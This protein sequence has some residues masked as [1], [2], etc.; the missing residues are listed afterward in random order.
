[1]AYGSLGFWALQ[2][3]VQ[4]LRREV[5]N[6]K[7]R[8]LHLTSEIVSGFVR[9]PVT[10]LGC[11]AVTELLYAPAIRRIAKVER[12]DH[13][14]L[15][16][17]QEERLDTVARLL[18]GARQRQDLA[19]CG[20]LDGSLVVVALPHDSHAS[21]TIHALGVG[22]H[23]L[24]EKPMARSLAECRAMIAAAERAERLL[25]VGHFRRAFPVVRII[26]KWIANGPLGRL[27]S[28]RFLEGETY[29]WPAKDTSLFQRA[30]AGGGVL[31]DAGSHTVDLILHWM[32]PAADLVYWDDAAG[33]VEANCILELSMQ[34]GV[35]GHVQISRDTPL[36]NEYLLNF[37]GGWVVYT[38]DVPTMFRWGL[39]DD[40]YNY[41]SAVHLSAGRR[42]DGLP[43][44]CPSTLGFNAAVD[45]QLT[46]LFAA[47]TGEGSIIC[48][49]M[50]ALEVVGVIEKCYSHRQPLNQRW[51]PEAEQHVFRDL[52]RR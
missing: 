11:G 10:I 29:S 33:G 13:V 30:R 36:A 45:L 1:L 19:E 14:T 51:L 47:M 42:V 12:F 8:Y 49:G 40:E 48:T 50:E 15:V 26:R 25:A 28:F 41:S 18:P 5:E 9:V 27:L 34:S 2:R 31:L 35:S 43:S 23:V 46:S 3:L 22:A 44:S 4:S 7:I 6:H 16:D 20:D 39:H 37:E 32:G 38:C 24:C 52:S 21:S 17:T